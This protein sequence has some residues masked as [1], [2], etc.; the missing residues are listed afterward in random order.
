MLLQIGLDISYAPAFNPNAL[1]T[2]LP[3]LA[4]ERASVLFNLAA[5]Y[6]QLGSSEDRASSQGL[7]QAIA[8]YQASQSSYVISKQRIKPLMIASQNAAGTLHYALSSAIPP[9]RPSI[10]EQDMPIELTEPF[11]ESLEF[12]MLAQA[13]ECVWQKAVMGS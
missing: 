12:L 5:L 2:I 4:Y 9:L 11:I 10:F 7:K 1:P 13:Q 3:N 8:L 6:S